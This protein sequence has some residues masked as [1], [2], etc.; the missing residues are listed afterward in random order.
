MVGPVFNLSLLQLGRVL[1]KCY[2]DMHIVCDILSNELFF[3][4]NISFLQ[5]WQIWFGWFCNTLRWSDSKSS[6]IS[7]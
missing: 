6:R 7:H 3:G 2:G 4:Q 1:V 5:S